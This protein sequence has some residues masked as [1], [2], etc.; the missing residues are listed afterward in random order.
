MASFLHSY[1]RGKKKIK[2][3]ND[4]SAQWSVSSMTVSVSDSLPLLKW[5]HNIL[6]NILTIDLE[7]H[8]NL[9]TDIQ[10]IMVMK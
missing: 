5:G 9:F 7:E 3:E 1:M 10:D 8:S 4:A 2:K 6:S